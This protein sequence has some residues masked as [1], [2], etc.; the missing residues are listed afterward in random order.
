M[1]YCDKLQKYI[2]AYW[3]V[4]NFTDI[5]EITMGQ[6]PKGD[7]YNTER[8]GIALVNGPVE[9]GAYFTTKSKWT[10]SPTKLCKSKDQYIV[11]LRR[12]E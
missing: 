4:G 2:P 12:M 7:T 11:H 5:C 3:R 10:T 6:S 9:F 8:L 1:K